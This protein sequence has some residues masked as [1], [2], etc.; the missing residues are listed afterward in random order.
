MILSARYGAVAA[1]L[2]AGGGDAFIAIASQTLAS[3]SNSITFSSI[4]QDYKDL[5]LVCSTKMTSLDAYYFRLNGDTGSNY[6]T[7]S[8]AADPV[9]GTTGWEFNNQTRFQ[10]NNVVL[11]NTSQ[12]NAL[13]FTLFSY[14]Q[15]N[16]FKT[17]GTRLY[18]DNANTNSGEGIEIANGLWRN[19]GAVTTLNISNNFNFA[20]GS[21]FALYGIGSS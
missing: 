18:S 11:C 3:A 17:M 20:I 10:A 15:T 2:P 16:T 9:N 4:P 8:M 14:T 6:A 5:F 21:V 1:S 19:T 12:W 13:V 7:T